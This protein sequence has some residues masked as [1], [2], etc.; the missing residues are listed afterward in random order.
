M[1]ITLEEGQHAWDV[2][3]DPGNPQPQV[4][5]VCRDCQEAYV[6]KR[7]LSLSKG[8]GWYWMK[9]EPIRNGC[10]HKNGMVIY[11]SQADE[12]AG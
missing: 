12:Y 9:P 7:A 8:Y 3:S 5:P 11:N 4:Y 2:T 1:S 6:Y 10:K